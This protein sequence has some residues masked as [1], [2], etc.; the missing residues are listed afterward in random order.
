MK[1]FVETFRENIPYIA[2][3]VFWYITNNKPQFDDIQGGIQE[4]LR[5]WIS[6]YQ[7]DMNNLKED[8][9]DDFNIE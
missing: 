6:E 7:S 8:I 1:T 4:I 9:S 3:E 5:N 2:D